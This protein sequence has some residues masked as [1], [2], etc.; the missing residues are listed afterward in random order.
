M[1]PTTVSSATNNSS[2][3]SRFE[4]HLIKVNLIYF[5]IFFSVLGLYS[6]VPMT[7]TTTVSDKIIIKSEA[8]PGTVMH[9][10]EAKPHLLEPSANNF[11]PNLNS[12]LL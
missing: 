2:I 5:N 1:F 8:P 12:N 9:F 6:Q 4:L 11:N 3:Q 10:T 7:T